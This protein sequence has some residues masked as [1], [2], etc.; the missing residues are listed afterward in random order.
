MQLK[1]LQEIIKKKEAKNEFAIVTNLSTSESEIF[2]E[3]KELS[4]NLAPHLN[5]IKDFYKSKKK[6]RNRRYRII[7]RD[8]YKANK[9]CNNWSSS[10][11]SI[12][13]G[14]CKKP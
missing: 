10:H 12:F 1:T 9:S 2:E 11:C 8:I 7:F 14:F 5:Q 6:W 4:E 13:S 3:N